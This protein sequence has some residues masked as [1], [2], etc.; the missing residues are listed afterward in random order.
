MHVVYENG[1]KIFYPIK[2]KD[3]A[4]FQTTITGNNSNDVVHLH[5]IHPPI[6]YGFKF[7]Q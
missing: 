6:H 4:S 1:Q 5:Q 7:V 2:Y 3:V